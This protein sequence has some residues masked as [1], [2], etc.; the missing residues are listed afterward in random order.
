MF[1]CT[2]PSLLS[3]DMNVRYLCSPSSPEFYNEVFLFAASVLFF[4]QG[5][6]FGV[7]AITMHHMAYPFWLTF[8]DEVD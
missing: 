8:A 2:L 1:F 5:C 7:L 6:L 3:S 4:L